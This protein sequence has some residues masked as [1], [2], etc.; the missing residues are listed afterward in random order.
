[1]NQIVFNRIECTSKYF[2]KRNFAGYCQNSN[3]LAKHD[4]E[5][6][7]NRVTRP[8]PQNALG[9]VKFVFQTHIIYMH[10]THQK[11]YLTRNKGHLA[12][13]AFE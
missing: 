10:D 6:L 3:Y 7:E 11:L 13:V 12:M 9:Q 2:K 8:G 5:W 4:M 1:M